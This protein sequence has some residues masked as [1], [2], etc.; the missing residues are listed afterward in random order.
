MILL[1][2]GAVGNIEAA[3]RIVNALPGFSG[4]LQRRCGRAEGNSFGS[5]RWLL[6]ERTG[7][8]HR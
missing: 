7:R 1:G 5:F 8:P 4:D 2:A 6:A 3:M